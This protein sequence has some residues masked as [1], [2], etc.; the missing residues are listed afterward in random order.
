MYL[1]TCSAD[2]GSHGR[3]SSG[4]P[5]VPV[6]SGPTVWNEVGKADVQVPAYRSRRLK[7]ISKEILSLGLSM[8]SAK[9]ECLKLSSVQECTWNSWLMHTHCDCSISRQW[10]NVEDEFNRV[11]LT[12][13]I[14]CHTILTPD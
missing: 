12:M 6:G 2:W 4:S 9:G 10:F 3:S 5:L 13:K 14:G 11:G 1:E 7:T 8:H